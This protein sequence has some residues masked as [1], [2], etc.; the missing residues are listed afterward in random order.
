MTQRQSTGISTIGVSRRTLLAIGTA[1]L[2]GSVVGEIGHPQPSGRPLDY[3][4][5]AGKDHLD[6][7]NVFPLLAAWILLTTNGP[8]ET[9]DQAT[10]ASVANISG[11]SAQVIWNQYSQ[12]QQAFSTVRQAF[13][14][15]A[16]SF[17]NAA[18]Y[19]GGQCPEKAATVKPI[20]ALRGSITPSN[21][22]H[23]RK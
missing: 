2:V 10:I 8:A 22:P 6:S 3:G 7:S 17:A 18:P 15:I 12:N 16:K 19:S 5:G 4:T 1:T 14:T 11:N 21:K 20:A 9:V 23:V 13:G